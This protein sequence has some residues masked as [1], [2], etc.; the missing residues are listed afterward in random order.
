MHLI[1]DFISRANHVI[2]VYVIGIGGT[3]SHVLSILA[4]INYELRRQESLGFKVFAIDG[5]VVESS[6][7]GRQ[8]FSPSH[9]GLNKAEVMITAINR[10]YGFDWL[11][12][13]EHLT[14]K[15]FRNKELSN[16]LAHKG[17]IITCVDNYKARAII[18]KH[19]VKDS[20]WIDAGNS[21][22]S[23]QIIIGKKGILPN[24]LE[25]FPDLEKIDQ[26]NNAPDEAGCNSAQQGL[27]TNLTMATYIGYIMNGIFRDYFLNYRGIYLNIG[28]NL[29]I[30]KIPITND[31]IKS[32][33]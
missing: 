15:S 32:T 26:L 18:G 24:V 21:Y 7:I 6:N 9:L 11:A 23:G 22:S 19:M 3:G 8:N 13:Q 30:N 31:G 16:I 25:E 5:D 20:Y 27:L 17:I 33:K 12:M 29:S 1:K 14:V 28:E 4:K 10:F 2:P